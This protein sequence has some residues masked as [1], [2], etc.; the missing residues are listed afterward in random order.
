MIPP[1]YALKGL[2]QGR[3]T[4]KLTPGGLEDATVR[5][6]SSGDFA[7]NKALLENVILE[8][9]RAMRGAQAIERI[10]ADVLAEGDWQPFDSVRLDLQWV[11]NKMTGT[12]RFRS[13]RLNLTI[14]LNIEEAAVREI[15]ALQQQA[16]LEDIENIRAEPV[17]QKGDGE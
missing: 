11:E 2:A 5:L 4:A 8:Q 17:Q 1:D 6:V 7:M 14:D 13:A 12:A 16:R 15:L 9:L 10:S 3:I